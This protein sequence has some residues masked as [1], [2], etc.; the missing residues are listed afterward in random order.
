MISVFMKGLFVEVGGDVGI[1]KGMEG[2]A[3]SVTHLLS[4]RNTANTHH[5]LFRLFT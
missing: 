2:V 3:R 1:R 5:F 4:R